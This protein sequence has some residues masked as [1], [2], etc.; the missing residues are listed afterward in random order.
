[1]I[2][3]RGSIISWIITDFITRVMIKVIIMGFFDQRQ[4]QCGTVWNIDAELLFNFWSFQAFTVPDF[5]DKSTLQ[6]V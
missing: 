3:K 2:P 1:M 4:N 5:K 6:T